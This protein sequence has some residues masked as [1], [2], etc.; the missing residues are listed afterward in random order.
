MFFVHDGNIIHD[1]AEIQEENEKLQKEIR[2]KNKNII[3]LAERLKK[4]EEENKNIKLKQITSDKKNRDLKDKIGRIKIDNEEEMRMNEKLLEENRRIVQAQCE[5][6]S[7]LKTSSKKNSI[8][9][10][11]MKE[12]K[13]KLEKEK[14]D[15]QSRLLKMEK[16][17][18]EQEKKIQ[19]QKN[20]ISSVKS[21]MNC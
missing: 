8:E 6:I 15:L 5:E 7:S 12:I 17:K 10:L 4:T 2:L 18:E 13:V 21:T 14:E 20:K 16:I 3:E 1:G 19:S 11:A 9:F